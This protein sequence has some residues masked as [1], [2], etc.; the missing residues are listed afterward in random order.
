[1][2]T[3]QRAQL[4]ARANALDATVRIGKGSVTPEIIKSADEALE[5]NELIKLAVLNNCEIDI[6]EA[7]QTVAERTRSDVVQVVGRKFVL[8]RKAKEAQH[9]LKPR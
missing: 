1:M 4:R 2:T 9:V 3:K 6:K 7:A 8:Y 5:A